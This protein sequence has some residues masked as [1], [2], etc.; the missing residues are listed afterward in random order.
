[1]V[2]SWRMKVKFPDARVP[3]GKRAKMERYDYHIA[4]KVKYLLFLLAITFCRHRQLTKLVYQIR[5]KPIKGEE[6]KLELVRE[7]ML[8]ANMQE[9]VQEWREKPEKARLAT[10][11]P[12]PRKELFLHKTVTFDGY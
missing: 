3:K 12:Q 6:F 1:M 10:K 4:F 2:E 7:D 8:M 5:W 9:V 11:Y